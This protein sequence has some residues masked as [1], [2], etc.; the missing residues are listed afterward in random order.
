MAGFLGLNVTRDK[1]KGTVTLLQTGLIDKILVATQMEDCNI[2]FTPA[3]KVPLNKDL[4]GDHWC[5]EWNYRSIIGMLLYLAGSTCPDIAYDIHQCTR[6]LI[7]QK[8]PMKLVITSRYVAVTDKLV[9][10]G[11]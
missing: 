5:E 6:L 3:D 4:D 9:H 2:K 10:T 7:C 8:Y 11:N 1:D